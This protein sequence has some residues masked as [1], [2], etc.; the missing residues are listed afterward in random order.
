MNILDAAVHQTSR[1]QEA[2]PRPVSGSGI[3]PGMKHHPEHKQPWPECMKIAFTTTGHFDPSLYQYRI[4]LATISLVLLVLKSKFALFAGVRSVVCVCT[5][6]SEH[7]DLSGRL[8][9]DTESS[10]LQAG[11]TL[12]DMP[13]KD[14]EATVVCII[15]HGLH[16]PQI[17]G[18]QSQG[19]QS[20]LPNSAP[21]VT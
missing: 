5:H 8:L 7:L 9:V 13:P 20:P 16:Q 4:A 14:Q 12:S 18:V 19:W 2:L 6:V 15:N 3:A 17:S 11:R 10:L 1:D 21:H